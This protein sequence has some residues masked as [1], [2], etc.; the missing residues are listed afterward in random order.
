M[1]QPS[2]VKLD[3]AIEAGVQGRKSRFSVEKLQ[4]S[5]AP[6]LASVLDQIDCQAKL[7]ENRSRWADSARW[8]TPRR[9]TGGAPSYKLTLQ[10]LDPTVG[11]I[12]GQA[13]RELPPERAL[14]RR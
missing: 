4:A 5:P 8:K 13:S 10:L 7:A 2:M 14:R 3:E 1:P 11:A 9:G 12:A 6:E